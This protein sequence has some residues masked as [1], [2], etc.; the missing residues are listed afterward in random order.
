MSSTSTK[1]SQGFDFALTFEPVVYYANALNGNSLAKY[2]KVTAPAQTNLTDVAVTLTVTSL[3]KSLIYPW[4]KQI[5]ELSNTPAEFIDLELHWDANALFGISDVAPGDVAVTVTNA[6]GEVLA[7]TAWPIEVASSDAWSA[8]DEESSRILSA[9]ARPNDPGL[10]PILDDAAKRLKNIDGNTGLSG[11]QN[12]PHVAAMVQAIYEA[13]QALEITYSNPPASWDI[14][15]Q[16]IRSTQVILE[17]R[18]GT[19]LDTAVLFAAL[20]ENIGLYPL[21]A[22]VPGHAYVGFWTAKAGST[23]SNWTPSEAEFAIRDSVNYLDENYIS[24]FETTVVCKGPNKVSFEQAS[25][26]GRKNLIEY[27]SLTQDSGYKSGFVDVVANRR[28]ALGRVIPMPAVTTRPDGTVEITEYKPE[29]FSVSKLIDQLSLEIE[30]QGP[31]QNTL[32]NPV[33]PRLKK[34]LDSLLDL[35]LRNPLI[36]FRLRTSSL[37]LLTVPDSLGPLE[38][39]LAKDVAFNVAIGEFNSSEPVIDERGQ[40]SANV[41]Q[42]VVSALKSKTLIPQ[43]GAERTVSTLRKM[44]SQAKSFQE[45]TGSNGLFLALG[46]LVWVPE[47]KQEIR[48]PLILL[49]MN[50]TTKNRARDFTLQLDQS[51]AVTP[52]YSLA[53]KLRRDLGLKLDDLVNLKEDDAGIDVPGTFSSIREKLLEAGLKGFRVDEDA[54]L[55]F[56]DFS[57]YRLWKDLVDNW[58]TFERNPL[59]KHLIYTP[60]QIFEDTN[61]EPVTADLDEL[62]AELPIEADS[63]QALAVAQAVSGKTFV[64][65]GPPGTGKSQTI[66]N[67]LARALHD[68]KRMLFVAEKKDALDVVKER[69]DAIGLGAFSLDLHD[70]SMSLKSVKEQLASVIDISIADDR[71]G[72]DAALAEYKAAVE[73]LQTYRDRLHAQSSLGESVSS[74]LDKYLSIHSNNELVV[75]GSFISSS[76]VQDKEELLNTCKSLV[77]LGEQAGTSKTNPWSFAGTSSALSSDTFEEIKSLMSNIASQHSAVEKMPLGNEYLYNVEDLAEFARFTAFNHGEVSTISVNSGLSE[78]AR[79]D[80]DFTEAGLNEL[81]ALLSSQP[82]DLSKIEDIDANA[83]VAE[84]VATNASGGLFK[85]GKLKAIAKKINLMLG[86]DFISNKAEIGEK[87]D[88]LKSLKS[89]G[90][91]CADSLHKIEGFRLPAELNVFAPGAAQLLAEQVHNLSAVIAL[92]KTTHAAGPNVTDV[93]TELQS[94]PGGAEQLV[95]LS[96]SLIRLFVLLESN[97]KSAKL[98]QGDSVLGHRLK[99][100]LPLWIADATNYNLV[101]LTRWVELVATA[102]SFT[103]LNIWETI[104]PVL[105]GEVNYNEASTSFLRGY[106]NALILGLL[107]ERGFNTFNGSSNSDYI[108]KLDEAH[109]SLRARLPKIYGG[110]LLSR[111]GFDGSTKVGAIGDLLLTL[112][113]ARTRRDASVRGLLQKHWNIITKITPCVLA[114]PDSTVRFIDADLEPFDLVIFDEAS[115][116]R[117]AN[118]LGSLGRAKAAVIVGDTKQMPPTS[119]AQIRA[120]DE[121]EENTADEDEFL[122][123]DVE[124]ILSQCEVARVPDVLLNW[125]YRSEDESLIAYSNVRYYKSKLNSFPS[126]ASSSDTQ[127]LSF[128]LVKGGQFIRPGSQ[129][130]GKKKGTNPA[131]VEAIVAEI[132]RRVTDPDLSQESIGVVTFNQ[133]Q[134]LAIQDALT[135]SENE[136]IQDALVNGVGGEEIFVKNLETVQGSERDIILFSVAFSK[137]EKGDLPLNFGPLNN[138]GGERRLNVAITRARKAM[139]V[140]CSFLPI[141]LSKREPTSQ[142]LK[143]LS[144]FLL[145][146][147]QGADNFPGL[148]AENEIGV[149]RH[150]QNIA[151]A[152]R[153]Q[154]HTVEEEFGLS[155]FKV[156]LAIFDSPSKNKAIL[157]ILLDGARWNSRNTVS[158]RDSLPV[159][160][161]EKKMGWGRIDRI[162][163][164]AWLRDQEGELERIKVSFDAALIRANAPIEKRPAR[165]LAPKQVISD[166]PAQE[167]NAEKL[168]EELSG[169][170]HNR[171]GTQTTGNITGGFDP[172][173][174]LLATIPEYVPLRPSILGSQDSLNYLFDTSVKTAIRSITDQLTAQEGPIHP[175]RFVKFIGSCFAF[176]RLTT[177]RQNALLNVDLSGHPRDEE[178]FIFP[179]GNSTASLPGWKRRDRAPRRISEISLQEIANACVDLTR[180]MHGF[181]RE[182]LISE[183]NKVLSGEKLSA[184]HQTRIESAIALAQTQNSLVVNGDYL[185][186]V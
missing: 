175:V 76:S 51:S 77:I 157:G 57:T 123:G 134:K 139:K 50:L 154:G 54:V 120:A 4:A 150:R 67:M 25:V 94:N 164:P 95:A 149:D 62:V 110:E 182:A 128:E 108:R 2:L 114:S 87:A 118:S 31:Q 64:L 11:Y 144:E 147:E 142:G 19:C 30:A 49:P 158:D 56:F 61:T 148:F 93:M 28:L 102:N 20:L 174:T 169:S 101:Q 45:E 122:S 143:N 34:W 129:S 112:N 146:A 52:N 39:M 171:S 140:F 22:L 177:T 71:I 9:F 59:V 32:D 153:A 65:Q 47:G 138:V 160:V 24:V 69:L 12:G 48:S 178:G 40:A 133:E 183:A 151:S 90:I 106:Y 85:A 70:K 86:V 83:L 36:N 136:F 5:K 126:P 107:V 79:S 180:V 162:W 63:S 127:G 130:A 10:R 68:G 17:E 66:T 78:V 27:G 99:E 15:G 43:F 172:Y 44:A 81:A 103:R 92:T 165:T 29:E 26:A 125:H 75:P 124:S 184:V 186:A 89:R 84:V 6:D 73:P 42:A 80:R 111:R 1:T 152:L 21:I 14:P 98:W 23:G 13:V 161:L 116:I 109:K 145:L 168:N 121:E 88:L 113:Q 167:Q 181:R 159:S 166:I 104:A 72:F 96:N 8:I 132:T 179:K 60:N 3:G 91:Q 38:D 137:N 16:R 176:E 37:P 46:S 33:P 35:S 105:S 55:G 18:V 141:E 135:N 74:A 173:Q 115:Q 185:N 41:E 156:D 58:R 163:L 82:V 7:D 100:T 53:E 119:V 131:E 155:G 170:G 117:V 97:E